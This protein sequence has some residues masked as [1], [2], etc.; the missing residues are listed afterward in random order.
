MGRV[1]LLMRGIQQ[2]GIVGLVK[3][4]AAVLAGPAVEVGAVDQLAPAVPGLVAISAAIE[5]RLLPCAVTFTTGVRPRR[6]QVRPLGGLRPWPDSSSKQSQ[7]P[8]SAAV[9]TGKLPAGNGRA[10]ADPGLVR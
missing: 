3:A 1:E 9:L 10:A 6:P 2:A 4:L 7:A 8:R 5:T